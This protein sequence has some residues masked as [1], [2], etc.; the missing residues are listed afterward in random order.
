MAGKNDKRAI[1]IASS[2]SCQPNRNLFGVGAKLKESIFK[3][4]NQINPLLQP[5]HEFCQKNESERGQTQNWYRRKQW[6][7]YPFAS[8]VDVVLQDAWVLY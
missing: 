4:N 5:E 2:E 1:Y 8:M 3:S 6:W 7:W